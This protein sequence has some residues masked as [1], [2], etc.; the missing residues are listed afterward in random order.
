VTPCHSEGEARRIFPQEEK[1]LPVASQ[2]LAGA[3][4]HIF[5]V[6]YASLSLR[7]TKREERILR[8]G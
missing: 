2:P 7:M 1:I 3:A 4:S 6:G 5:D 8:L